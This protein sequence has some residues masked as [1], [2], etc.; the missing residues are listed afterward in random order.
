MSRKST[1]AYSLS[2]IIVGAIG[3]IFIPVLARWL[4]EGDMAKFVIF[5]TNANF[6]ILIVG[7]GLD[8]ALAREFHEAS[9][10]RQLLKIILKL[11]SCAIPLGVLGL[12][13]IKFYF[14]GAVSSSI[15]AGMIL[16]CVLLLLNRIYSSYIRMSGDG[17]AYGI[18]I[19]TPKIFQILMIALIGSQSVVTLTYDIVIGIFVLSAMAALCYEIFMARRIGLVFELNNA[20]IEKKPLPRQLDLL[21]FGMPLIPGALAYY[22]ISASAIYVVGANGNP[23]ELVTTSLAISLGGGL[24]LLQAVFTTQWLPFAYRWYALK[25]PTALYGHVATIVTMSC[26]VLLLANLFVLPYLPLLFPA[27]YS[28][29]P[30]LVVLVVVWNLLLP[31]SIVGNFGIPVK[32][33]SFQSMIIS[34]V[35]AALSVGM[36]LVANKYFGALGALQAVLVAFLVTLAWQC[37][38]STKVWERIVAGH[39]YLMVGAMTGCGFSFSLGYAWEAEL[40]MAISIILY[41]PKFRSSCIQARALYNSSGK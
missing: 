10:P 18:D 22:A 27:K 5:Q 20:G 13:I 31:I 4:T 14:D 40:L 33:L 35:G 2:P 32:R 7:L 12:A 25:A 8:Q 30:E 9:S 37:E 41:F 26:A 19:V 36:S 24:A 23:R 6:F 3:F 28:G 15:N 16:A 17:V 38:L 11:V 1:I 21:K 29:L 39:H 34:I